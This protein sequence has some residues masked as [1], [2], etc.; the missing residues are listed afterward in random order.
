M[1]TISGYPIVG[2]WR[3][4]APQAKF[5]ENPMQDAIDEDRS[6]GVMW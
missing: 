6:S 2:A 3:K 1:R 5:R 4:A